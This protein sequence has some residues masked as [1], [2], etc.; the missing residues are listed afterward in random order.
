MY[1]KVTFLI[2][3]TTFICSAQAQLA[4]RHHYYQTDVSQY[5]TYRL[6]AFTINKKEADPGASTQ[7]SAVQSKLHEALSKNGFEQAESPDLLIFLKLKVDTLG[8]QLPQ[9]ER[10][11]L[12]TNFTIDIRQNP[13]YDKVFM[14][15]VN[16]LIVTNEKSENRLKK[17]YKKFFKD[18]K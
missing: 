9:Q 13:K 12:I 18:F 11:E 15:T 2:L 10:K 16:G 8:A 7:V 1:K 3:F 6:A 5:K 17:I 4:F 14:G